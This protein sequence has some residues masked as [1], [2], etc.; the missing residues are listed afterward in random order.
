MYGYFNT[1][2]RVKAGEDARRA[3]RHASGILQPLYAMGC[4]AVYSVVVLCRSRFV[5]CIET[6]RRQEATF[7]LF[8]IE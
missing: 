2:V 6:A 8:N 5:I 3:L 1:N 7:G 4:S